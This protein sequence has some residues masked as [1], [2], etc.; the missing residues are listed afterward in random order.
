MHEQGKYPFNDSFGRNGVIDRRYNPRLGFHVLRHLHGAL[1]DAQVLE[2]QGDGEL[3]DGRYF[4]FGGD[5][6]TW[7]L[8]LPDVPITNPQIPADAVSF[9]GDDASMIDLRSGLVSRIDCQ[10]SADGG[11]SLQASVPANPVLLRFA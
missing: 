9:I 4:A 3:T 10:V 5:G 2:A 6:S 7:V 11:I 1:A 8:V